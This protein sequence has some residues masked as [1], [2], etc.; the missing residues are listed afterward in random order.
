MQGGA[1]CYLSNS[2]WMIAS[3]RLSME[4]TSVPVFERRS[5]YWS[6]HLAAKDNQGEQTHAYRLP[7]WGRFV[8]ARGGGGGSLTA[9]L[10]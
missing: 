5:A 1:T 9:D 3:R 7:I 6:M 4:A 2:R 10:P 8:C